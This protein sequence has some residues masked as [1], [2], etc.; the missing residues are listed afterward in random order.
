MEKALSQLYGI[1]F[2]LWG[3]LSHM[4]TIA[5]RGPEGALTKCV[6]RV[7]VV[8]MDGWVGQVSG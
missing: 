7:C 6:R 5:L 4:V 8:R 3:N 2:L 1:T